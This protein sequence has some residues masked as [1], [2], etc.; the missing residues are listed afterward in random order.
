[1][2]VSINTAASCQSFLRVKNTHPNVLTY[3]NRPFSEPER[4]I[5]LPIG[6]LDHFECVMSFLVLIYRYRLKGSA[7]VKIKYPSIVR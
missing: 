7:F 1:M 3:L 6:K 2:I 4:L 5:G